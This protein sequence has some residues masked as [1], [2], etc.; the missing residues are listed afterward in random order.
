MMEYYG[1]DALNVL[2]DDDNDDIPMILYEN[3]TN[4]EK[5]VLKCD[6][7]CFIDYIVYPENINE[8]INDNVNEKPKRKYNKNMNPA[9]ISS[10]ETLKY[11]K[12]ITYTRNI[13]NK[14][15]IY[16]NNLIDELIKNNVYDDIYDRFLSINDF[17]DN[18]D[19]VLTD[20][21]LTILK[22]FDFVEPENLC[23]Y[24]KMV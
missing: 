17:Y 22:M 3:D 11:K 2:N 12:L 9:C 23:E 16:H 20:E 8:S 5:P 7:K 18:I 10:Q 24:Y 21:D 4:E 15:K 14:K 1:W 6:D 13:N 19:D